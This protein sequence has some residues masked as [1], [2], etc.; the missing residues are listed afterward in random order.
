MTIAPAF[1]SSFIKIAKPTKKKNKETQNG[2][3][4]RRKKTTQRKS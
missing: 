1:Q 2:Q 4:K 3:S